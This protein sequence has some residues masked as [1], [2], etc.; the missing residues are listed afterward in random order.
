[1]RIDVMPVATEKQIV[2]IEE[3]ANHVWHNYYKD[4]FSTQQIS[5]ML[6]KYHSREAL[7]RQMEEGYIYYMLFSDGNFAGYMC[8]KMYSDHAFIS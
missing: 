3:T 7:K 6:E 1:M 5:Y 4:I 8:Y 2:E